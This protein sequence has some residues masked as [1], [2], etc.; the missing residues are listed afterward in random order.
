MP[1]HEA[2]A[3]FSEFVGKI[4]H[5]AR[6]AQL[7][8]LHDG[9]AVGRAVEPVSDTGHAAP[10]ERPRKR[11]V[12]IEDGK[13]AAVL[14]KE[15]R[16]C[17][18]VSLHRAEEIEMIA[19]E[20]GE[21]GGVVDDR[22]L[23]PEG[24]RVRRDFHDDVL[25]TRLRHVFEEREEVEGIGRRE[26]GRDDGVLKARAKR[27]D[28]PRSFFR[29]LQDVKEKMRRRRLAVGARDGDELELPLGMPAE[30]RRDARHCL[31]RVGHDEL[32]RRQGQFVFGDK[33]R[34]APF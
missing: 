12:R 1:P 3:R 11:V 18:A 26:F 16:F 29:R 4:E 24:E 8:F 13:A 23:L 19:R 22:A 14:L 7:F 15:H 6:R 33:S 10:F 20:V 25:R 28:E 5:D 32:R 27:A 9:K 17:R 34:R 21:D 31:A 30:R 2:Q